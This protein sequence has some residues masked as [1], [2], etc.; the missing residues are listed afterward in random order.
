MTWELVITVQVLVSAAMTVFTR[1]L[2]LNDRKL[3]FVIGA[4]SYGVIALMGFIFATAFGRGIPTITNVEA[5]PYLA[6]EGIFIP[7]SWLLQY[8][9]ISMLG[10][11]NAVLATM[12]NYVGAAIT[13]FILLNENYTLAFF[14]GAL[15]ILSSV[16]LSF[17]IQPDTTHS[18][19]STLITKS[20][21]VITMALFFSIGIF[22]EKQA[23]ELIGVWNYAAFGWGLQFLGAIIILVFFG[24]HEFKHITRKSV[25]SGLILGFV[26]SISGGLFIYALSVG[27]LSNTIIA[28]SAK[29]AVTMFLAAIILKETNSLNV[30]IAAFIL[31]VLGLFFLI[32]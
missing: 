31:A 16:Y 4:L 27:T 24:R 17:R 10:A 6:S 23:I 12:L 11:S 26:T 30:R 5:W 14:I 18:D 8:K 1:R 25:Q 22:S 9:I 21:I 3:F 20:V 13:G 28:A 29:I 2:A 15:F 19:N 7:L 32:N